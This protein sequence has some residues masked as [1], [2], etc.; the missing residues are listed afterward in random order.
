ALT[1]GMI[2]IYQYLQDNVTDQDIISF[3]KPRVLRLFTGKRT[4]NTDLDHFT[5]SKANYLLQKRTVRT[6]LHYPVVFEWE[7]YI[8]LKKQ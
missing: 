8:L 5:T 1:P 6:R 2:E 4:V 3:H 7:H